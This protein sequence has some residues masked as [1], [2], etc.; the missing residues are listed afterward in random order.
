MF[1]FL[2]LPCLNLD[3]FNILTTFLLLKGK[4]FFPTNN[5]IIK[6]L[7]VYTFNSHWEHNIIININVI[8]PYSCHGK[9]TSRFPFIKQGLFIVFFFVFV[10]IIIM[11][12]RQSVTAKL[13]II[14]VNFRNKSNNCVD[15]YIWKHYYFQHVP[16]GNC[17]SNFK[18]IAIS[19]HPLTLIAYQVHQSYYKH[20]TVLD[21]PTCLFFYFFLLFIFP[22]PKHVSLQNL[23]HYC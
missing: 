15:F 14:V 17:D 20:S 8:S 12:N 9:M 5:A 1:F 23:F 13:F 7:H 22:L 6:K 16:L 4:L 18:H 3:I 2:G 21:S 19:T 10:F 11:I